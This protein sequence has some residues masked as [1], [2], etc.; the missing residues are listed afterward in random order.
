MKLVLKTCRIRSF[1]FQHKLFQLKITSIRSGKIYF[2]SPASVFKSAFVVSLPCTV[3]SLCSFSFKIKLSDYFRQLS[4][5]QKR[6]Y[7]CQHAFLSKKTKPLLTR[8]GLFEV[9]KDISALST[10]LWLSLSAS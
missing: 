2:W 3:S 7:Y 9:I 1:Y 8:Q 4:K 6:H 5:M 10:T